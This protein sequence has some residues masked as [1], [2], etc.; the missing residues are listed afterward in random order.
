MFYFC[1]LTGEIFTKKQNAILIILKKKCIFLSI[2]TN[3]IISDLKIKKNPSN[4]LL[5][6]ENFSL[7][8]LFNRKVLLNAYKLSHRD[9]NSY[10]FWAN[11][12]KS[13]FSF[14]KKLTAIF[15]INIHSFNKTKQAFAFNDKLFFFSPA[16]TILLV[17]VAPIGPQF[18]HT[19]LVV[20]N[21]KVKCIKF[22]RVLNTLS[23]Q[24]HQYICILV[25]LVFFLSFL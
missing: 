10:Y 7:G 14:R 2:Y 17:N 8:I 11:L 4:N 9:L 23:S 16:D 21:V 13:I 18:D 15:I 5:N 20:Q 22:I 19:M 25:Y 24:Q 6:N 3:H 1:H 12:F